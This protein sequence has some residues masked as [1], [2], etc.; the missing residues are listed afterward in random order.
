MISIIVRPTFGS[1]ARSFKKAIPKNLETGLEKQ[2]RIYA[3]QTEKEA[4]RLVSDDMVNVI[5][6]TLRRSIGVDNIRS[7]RAKI[8]A[9]VNYAPFLHWGTRYITPR[10]F[11][12]EGLK[13]AGDR[14]YGRGKNPFAAEIE[15][16]FDKG[17]SSKFQYYKQ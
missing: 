13:R 9:H 12:I 6:G 14:L 17:F 5:S 8:G 16:A 4:K 7:L 11:M 15:N 1:L 3:L 10:P 2:L